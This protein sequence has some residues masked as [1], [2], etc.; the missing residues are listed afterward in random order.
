MKLYNLDFTQI[1]YSQDVANGI[2]LNA[3]VAYEQ[4]KPL[5]NTTDYS[6]FKKDDTYSSNNP[7]APERLYNSQLLISIICL[8]QL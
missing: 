3:K 1:N 8:K 4:R 7:L 2:N 6:F 5:F